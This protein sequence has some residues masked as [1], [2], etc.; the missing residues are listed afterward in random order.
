MLTIR[1]DHFIHT[2]DAHIELMLERL[3]QLIERIDTMSAALDSLTNAVHAE[4]TVIDGAVTLLN[5][6]SAEIISL[7]DDPA[8]LTALAAEVN[9]KAQALA[10]A[11]TANT[12]TPPVA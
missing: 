2:D 4:E 1:V 5:G 9:Q 8:A 10:D 7:K 11:V 6:L 12:P 3:H